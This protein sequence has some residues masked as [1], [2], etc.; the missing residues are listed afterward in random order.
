MKLSKPASESALW[1]S[2]PDNQRLEQ[3][4]CLVKNKTVAWQRLF[5]YLSPKTEVGKRANS[6]TVTIFRRWDLNLNSNEI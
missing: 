2:L 3:W 6:E 1:F 5:P 4:V